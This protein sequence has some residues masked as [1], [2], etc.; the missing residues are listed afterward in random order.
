MKHTENTI[1]DRLYIDFMSRGHSVMC[2]NNTN[3]LYYV[4]ESDFISVTKNGM[5][6]EIEIKISKAD[7]KND[8][9]KKKRHQWLN[10]KSVTSFKGLGGK[11]INKT[12]I[13]CVEPVYDKGNHLPN[14]FY[15]ALPKGLIKLE[16]IPDYCGVIEVDEQGFT[17]Q[18][19]SPKQKRTLY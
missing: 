5:I 10:Q 13:R 6:H 2:H 17:T 14:Y 15:Y 7:F 4:G 16:D 11:I 12:Y 8:F 3:T 1:I 19:R 9:T 18:I